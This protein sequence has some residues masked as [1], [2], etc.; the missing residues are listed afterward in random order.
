MKK[1]LYHAVLGILLPVTMLAVEWKPADRALPAMPP[2]KPREEIR[3]QTPA[4]KF[5][6]ADMRWSLSLNGRWKFSGLSS[7]VTPF[8]APS[9]GELA[10]VRPE[11]D[12]K[13]WE[14]IP[15]PLNWYMVPKYSYSKVLKTGEA[16]DPVSAGGADAKKSS[17]A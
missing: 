10:F 17:N 9:A 3:I 8:P 4:G 11:F 5:R 2:L 6:P 1:S 15:V 12:D 13:T 16:V 7:S 14:E